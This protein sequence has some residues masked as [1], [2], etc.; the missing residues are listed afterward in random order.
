M[1]TL[2]A[3]DFKSNQDVRWCPG[4]G[5]YSILAVMQRTLPNF[6]TAKEKYVFISGIGCSSR[7]P[8]YMETYGFH[9]IH[10]RAPAVAAGVKLANPEL[11]VF[12]ITGD[13]DSMSIGGN[14]FIH[15]ARRNIDITAVIFNN[16]IYGLTKGQYS[17]TSDLG[18]KT[19][20]SPMGSIDYPFN[21]S[22][23]ALGAGSTF[24][25]RTTDK[26]TKHMQEMFK[27]AHEHKGFSIVEVLQN[28]H[29]FNDA[30]HADVTHKDRRDDNRVILEHG[31]PLIF[32]KEKDKAL[33]L[34][35][36][37]PEVVKLSGVN[38]KE[39]ILHDENDAVWANM[40]TR[41]GREEAQL[42]LPLGVLHRKDV[43]TYNEGVETQIKE[44]RAQKGN[45]D[46]K[47]LLNSGDTWV[48]D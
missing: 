27:R 24:Y 23:L 19:K 2:T 32:G 46:F 35:G 10:G 47:K 26:D 45:G 28:C 33:R 14:H 39:L 31:Q 18:T 3:K 6:D 4:C 5:D 12:M 15:A 8:Y 30:T 1:S 42:P 37:L 11:D 40:L 21:P 7:F 16:E 13:G 9:T 34:K 48:I 20:S 44:A 17:P 41:F 29:V 38:E 36:L 43:P 25:A 22:A